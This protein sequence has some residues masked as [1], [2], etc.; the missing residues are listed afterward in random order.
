MAG[1]RRCLRGTVRRGIYRLP[2]RLRHLHLRPQEPGD[3]PGGGGSAAASGPPLPG[4]AGSPAG[5]SGQGRGRHHPRRPAPLLFHQRRRRGGG[6]G[7]E[8]GENRHR[9]PVVYFHGGRL[10]RKEHG[11]RVHGRKEHLSHTLHPHGAAGAARGVR[12]R[13]GRPQGGEKPRC[14]GREGSRHHCGAHSGRGG[15]HRASGGLSGRAARHLRRVRRG[16]DFRRNSDGHGQNRRHVALRGR[17]SRPRHYDLRQG[18]R[19]RHHAHHRHHLP[20]PPL[21]RGAG[22]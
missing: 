7:T 15:H 14:R 18:L 3:S 16:S 8:A 10:P 21:D 22:G 2:G 20:P 11:R 1:P 4:A 6:D 13:R 9:R 19:R 17:G 5:L 12:Q